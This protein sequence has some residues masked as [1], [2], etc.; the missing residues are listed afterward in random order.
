MTRHRD[1][2]TYAE[3]LQ[4]VP[5]PPELEGRRADFEERKGRTKS[6]RWDGP[7][8][9]AI[10]VEMRAQVA[11]LA[12]AQLAQSEERARAAERALQEDR[13]RRAR[14]EAAAAL[15]A[16]A[17]AAEAKKNRREIYV[18]LFGIVAGGVFD[19]LMDH[20]WR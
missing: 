3:D 9:D 5:P 18:L 1:H 6:G 17:N 10:M 11:R 8:L 20:F 2:S 12:A 4:S 14:A 15:E 7:E 13:D 19:K 16:K